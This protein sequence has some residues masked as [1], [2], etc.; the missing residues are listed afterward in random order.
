MLFVEINKTSILRRRSKSLVSTIRKQRQTERERERERETDRQRERERDR[1]TDRETETETERD[2][3]RER[4]QKYNA[5]K[6]CSAAQQCLNAIREE[7]LNS[8]PQSN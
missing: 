2:R 6:R 8:T 5:R 1:Q 4:E 7:W 3:D